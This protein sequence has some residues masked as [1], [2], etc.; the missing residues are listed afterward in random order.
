MWRND[1]A[2][3]MCSERQHALDATSSI[4]RERERERRTWLK[5][6]GAAKLDIARVAHGLDAVVGLAEE[7]ADD[8]G[9]ARADPLVL[10]EREAR[11][12]GHGGEGLWR[13]AV[14]GTRMEGSAPLLRARARWIEAVL[15][16][17][18]S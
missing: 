11:V 15:G 18:E 4:Q 3:S 12:G 2:A 7:R 5:D 17:A 10:A 9:A 1:V 13:G 16:G 8:E 6:E 14:E